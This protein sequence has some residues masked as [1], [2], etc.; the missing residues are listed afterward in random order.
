MSSS[1]IEVNKI[2]IQ[3]IT[4]TNGSIQL[5]GE[6]TLTIDGTEETYTI[7]DGNPTLKTT[8]TE[9]KL[10]TEEL[11]QPVETDTRKA[12]ININDVVEGL[13]QMFQQGQ[14]QPQESKKISLNFNKLTSKDLA[15]KLDAIF[16]PSN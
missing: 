3:N 14:E 11:K 2:T 9:T 16:N 4:Y 13:K 10:K 8:D 7:Q 12:T 15:Q 5:N 1:E 6:I